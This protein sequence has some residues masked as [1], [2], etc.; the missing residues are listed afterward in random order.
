MTAQAHIQPVTFETKVQ[1]LSDLIGAE[2]EGELSL[3]AEKNGFV[4]LLYKGEWLARLHIGGLKKAD[5]Y[6][7][8]STIYKACTV[9]L[10]IEFIKV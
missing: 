7:K 5:I 10:S 2:T 8:I 1:A 4:S 9:F 6:E 3:T